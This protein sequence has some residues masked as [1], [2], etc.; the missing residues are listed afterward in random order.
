MG[1][2]CI[3]FEMDE[4]YIEYACKRLSKIK[5]SFDSV[6]RLEMETKSP[7]VSMQKLLECGYIRPGQKLFSKDKER[8]V[9]VTPSGHVYDGQEELF[10]T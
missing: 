3:G 10:D 7:R 4:T 6:T 8:E 2:N 9:V 5:P 1:R